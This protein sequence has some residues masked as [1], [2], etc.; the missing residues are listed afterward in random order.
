MEVVLADGS[1]ANAKAWQNP[2]LFVA[3]K[4]GSNN[5][6]IVTRFDL[7][8]YP[9]GDFWGGFGYYTSSTVP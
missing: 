7:Q 4:G 5:F 9:Q 3:L 8:I 2:D 1:T 6:G